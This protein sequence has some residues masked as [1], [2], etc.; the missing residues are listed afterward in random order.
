MFTISVGGEHNMIKNL[1]Q[2]LKELRLLNNL[3]QKEV[4]KKLNVSPS[5][6]SGYETGERT[7]STDN[8][9]SLSYLYKCSTDYLLGKTSDAPVVMLDT[10]GLTP[11]Q[12]HVLQSLIKEMK[13]E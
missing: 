2:K 5:I 11:E 6:I 3:S 13:R 10:T 4:A 12:I 7:P 1:P 8:L 9:L